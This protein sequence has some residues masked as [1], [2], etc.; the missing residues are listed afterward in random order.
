MNTDL[1]TDSSASLS[2]NNNN[3]NIN[4]NASATSVLGSPGAVLGQLRRH[5]LNRAASVRRS[6]MGSGIDDL[7]VLSDEIKGGALDDEAREV[8]GL[9]RKETFKVQIL[10]LIV[11]LCI[12]GAG[13]IISIYTYRILKDQE[14]QDSRESV[15]GMIPCL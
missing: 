1:S 5:S 3:N 2:N 13:T 15:R 6:S 7:S 14:V 11:A 12:L 4:R 8:R 10:R 9:A